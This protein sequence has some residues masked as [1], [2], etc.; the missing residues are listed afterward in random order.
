MTIRVPTLAHHPTEVPVPEATAYPPSVVADTI[1]RTIEL[2]VTITDAALD[3]RRRDLLHPG[4]RNAL[5]RLRARGPLPRHRD[6]PGDR[7]A[8]GRL[9]AGAAGGVPRYRCLAASV[10]ERC[11]T[12]IWASWRRRGLYDP[13]VCPVCVA[14]V[15]D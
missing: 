14:A 9:S 12:R 10:G 1:M 6:P 5:S 3:E 4:A 11:S 2:G 7:S 15:D 8:G 13:A